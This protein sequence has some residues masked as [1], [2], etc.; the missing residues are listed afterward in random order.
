MGKDEARKCQA[1]NGETENHWQSKQNTTRALP[2]VLKRAEEN[3]RQNHWESKRKSTR[4]G[5]PEIKES[6]GE[7]ERGPRRFKKSVGEQKTE[8]KVI[9]SRAEHKNV[10]IKAVGRKKRNF[11]DEE[12]NQLQR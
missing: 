3:R 2:T 12:Q 11:I 4:A 1:K 5:P 10:S 9:S 6:G 7:Q 8:S